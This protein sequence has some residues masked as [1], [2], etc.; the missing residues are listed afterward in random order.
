M[1][2]TATGQASGGTAAQTS[3]ISA[4]A[5][6]DEARW[7]PFLALACQLAIDLP[8]PRF[9]VADFLK[10]RAGSV[11]ATD[12][13]VTHDVPLRVNGTVIAWGEFDGSRRHLAVRVTELA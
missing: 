1:A 2:A 12:W 3:A 10:L 13:R 8:L 9:R 5:A 7:R 11:I 6:V 4:T